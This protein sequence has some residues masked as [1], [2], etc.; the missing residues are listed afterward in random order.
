M[1]LYYSPGSCSMASH[2]VL[3]ELKIPFTLE[4][5]DL[6]AKQTQSGE[7]F[8][9]INPKGYVPALRLDSKDV[10][11]EGAAILQYL[12]DQKPEMKL[13]PPAGTMERYRLQEWLNYIATEVHKGFSPLWNSKNSEEVKSNA[14][15]ILF[16]KFNFLAAHLKNG[17]FLMG[18]QFTIADAY[19]FTVLNWSDLLKMEMVKWPELLGYMEKIRTRPSVFK[20]LNDEGLVK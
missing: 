6:R 5:V 9:T 4:K 3:N 17:A 16:K 18:N 14:R 12:G 10:L 8:T 15:E 2:I 13:V 19:L 20:T 7:D 1:K 11:T